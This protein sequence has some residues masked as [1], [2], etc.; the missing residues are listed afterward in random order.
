MEK[1]RWSCISLGSVRLRVRVLWNK[2]GGEI[3]GPE[4]E[5]V[6]TWFVKV[7]MRYTQRN[8]VCISSQAG[9]G[10]A[11]PFCATGEGGVTRQLSTAEILEQVRAAAGGMPGPEHR[12]L[13]NVVVL[14]VGEALA[15]FQPGLGAVRCSNRPP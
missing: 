15:D 13:F 5:V 14:G 8:T 3:R 9:C 2:A 7:L 4:R 10:M 6:G 12:R 11:C 1:I